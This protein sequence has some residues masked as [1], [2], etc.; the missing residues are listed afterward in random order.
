MVHKL[1]SFTPL[2]FCLTD[3]SS[4]EGIMAWC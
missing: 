4:K 1:P 3:V 2:R